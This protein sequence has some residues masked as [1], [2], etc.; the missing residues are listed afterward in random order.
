MFVLAMEAKERDAEGE[1]DEEE[2]AAENAVSGV[3]LEAAGKKGTSAGALTMASEQ[4]AA[5]PEELA[6]GRELQTPSPVTVD[7]L[8]LLPR[9]VLSFPVQ[10]SILSSFD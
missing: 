3:D 2:A 1:P 8:P 10:R 6:Q 4:L 9:K 7:E 5:W